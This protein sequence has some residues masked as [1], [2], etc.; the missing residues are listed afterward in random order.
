VSL[1]AEPGEIVGVIGPN[2]AGKTTLLRIIAGE[3]AATSG[4]AFIAGHRC[5]TR[6][7]RALVG[8]AAEPPLAPPELTGLEWLRYLAGHCARGGAERL[9]LVRSAIELGVL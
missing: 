1:S 9:E 7:A 5:G 2:G 8:Y 4:S 3:L 6:A